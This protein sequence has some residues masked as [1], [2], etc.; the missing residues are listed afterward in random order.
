MLSHLEVR[1]S[2]SAEPSPTT[3]NHHLPVDPP[4]ASLSNPQRYRPRNHMRHP[5][6]ATRIRRTTRQHVRQQY[7]PIT[8]HLHQPR[9]PN[10]RP[11]RRRQRHHH[12]RRLP[13]QRSHFLIVL[14]S[15]VLVPVTM[16]VLMLLV[17]MLMAIPLTMTVPTAR[18]PH[19]PAAL[20]QPTPT[21]SLHRHAPHRRHR[22]QQK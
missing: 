12:Q 2:Q 6:P 14:I 13:N 10:R 19:N 9:L 4:A 21:Q 18:R 16:L 15:I 11:H 17:L 5:A 1:E 8:R 20:A 3:Q 7:L 22:Q